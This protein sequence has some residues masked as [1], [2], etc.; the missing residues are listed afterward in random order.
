M[1]RAI[2]KGEVARELLRATRAGAKSSERAGFSGRDEA[3]KLETTT[4]L[5]A[6]AAVRIHS[7]IPY[8][9]K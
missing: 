6:A 4:L 8:S 3:K 2:T 5:D 7:S 1:G 9:N